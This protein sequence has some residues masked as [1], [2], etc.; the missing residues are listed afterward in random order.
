MVGPPR[1]E[2]SVVRHHARWIPLTRVDASPGPPR[3]GAHVLA[4]SGPFAR[5]GAPGLID[6]M[7]IERFDPPAGDAPGVALFV[8]RGPLLLGEA[9]IEASRTTIRRSRP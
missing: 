9:P 5:H 4:G 2:V 7:L 3:L 8:K 6:R 1:H